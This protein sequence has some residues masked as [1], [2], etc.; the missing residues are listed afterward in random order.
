MNNIIFP[1]FNFPCDKRSNPLRLPCD[2]TPF[3]IIR[4]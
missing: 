1:P 2:N 4:Y 3:D